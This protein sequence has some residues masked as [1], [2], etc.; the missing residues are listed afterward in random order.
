MGRYRA[1]SQQWIGQI[2]CQHAA[3]RLLVLPETTKFHPTGEFFFFYQTFSAC[4]TRRALY[5]LNGGAGNRAGRTSLSVL[6]PFDEAEEWTKILEILNSCNSGL[7]ST[8]DVGDGS[9]LLGAV[10]RE[11]QNRL[12]EFLYLLRIDSAVT[13]STATFIWSNGFIYNS[14]QLKTE[15]KE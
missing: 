2:L 15:K 11:F 5:R 14:I 3:R 8:E 10:Q 6:S 7:E 13:S 1:A 12:G 4:I 9:H